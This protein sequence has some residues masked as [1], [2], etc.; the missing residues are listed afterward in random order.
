MIQLRRSGQRSFAEGLIE[1]E[2]DD[3]WEPWMRQADKVLEDEQL[4]SPVYEALLKRHAKSRTRG[5]LGTPAEIVLLMLLLKHLRNW[6]FN[7]IEREV[8]ANL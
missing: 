6:S 1:E 2:V 7:A 3:L 5:R 8:R 4:I